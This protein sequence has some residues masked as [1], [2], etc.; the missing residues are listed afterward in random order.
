MLVMIFPTRYFPGLLR[1]IQN[2]GRKRFVV[3]VDREQIR[4]NK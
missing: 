3:A 2:T 1:D 4:E